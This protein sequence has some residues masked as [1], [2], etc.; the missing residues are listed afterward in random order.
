MIGLVASGVPKT[1]AGLI[2]FIL[3]LLLF[4]LWATWD[5]A[6]IARRKQDYV[7]KSY[8]R[9]YFYLAV[10]I[11][12]RLFAQILLPLSPIRAFRIPSGSMEPAVRIG[13]HVY[14][15]MTYYRSNKPT[16][17]DVAVFTSP[18]S[19]PTVIKR[20]VGLEGEQIEIRDKRVYI[21]G[22]PLIDPWGHYRKSQYDPP[23][24]DPRLRQRDNL[25]PTKIP[26]GNCLPSG[27]QP[28]QQLRQPLLWASSAL[29]AAGPPALRILGS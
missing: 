3:V 14:A 23:F 16:R 6:R 25:G 26:A 8:N 1:F 19:G 2:I 4:V 15:D 29:V 22:Q 27:R 13:D 28:R 11:A 7:L 18:D 10:V 20:V 21:N 24:E 9:W 17:G 12:V 5:V